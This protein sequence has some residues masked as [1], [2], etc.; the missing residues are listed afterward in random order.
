MSRAFPSAAPSAVKRLWRSE[1]VL[2]RRIALLPAAEGA[3]QLDEAALQSLGRFK[4]LDQVCQLVLEC[5]SRL[6]RGRQLI[7][8]VVKGLSYAFELALERSHRFE[9]VGEVL[10]MG[11]ETLDRLKGCRNFRQLFL[12]SPYRAEDLRELSQLARWL[13]HLGQPGERLLGRLH[14]FEELRRCLVGWKSD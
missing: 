8:L 5:R 12:E 9:A 2:G 7:K 3:R 14:R 1:R 10:K 11:L 13:H 6:H 4:C